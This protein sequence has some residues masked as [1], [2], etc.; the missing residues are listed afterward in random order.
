MCQSTFGARI[1]NR[2]TFQIDRKLDVWQ[3]VRFTNG[4]G[5]VIRTGFDA[6]YFI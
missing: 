6:P 1:P 5:G 4:E 3:L 2:Q